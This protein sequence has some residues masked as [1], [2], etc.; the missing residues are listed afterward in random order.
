MKHQFAALAGFLS[1]LSFALAESAPVVYRASFE[2]AAHHEAR[3]TA[4]FR[5]LVEGPFVFRMSRS[6]PGRYAL[7]EFAKNVYDVSAVDG[8]GRALEVEQ[9]D[10]YS[11]RVEGHDGAVTVSYTLYADRADGTYS[12]I[13]RTHAHLNMPATFIWAEG[14][15]DRTIEISFS[16]P[17]RRWKAATQ[18][19]PS[20]GRLTFTAPD[21]QYFMDSPTELSAYDLRSWKLPDGQTVRLA[22]H[23]DGN[24]EDMDRYAD[25][26]KKIVAEQIEIFGAAP[27]FDHGVY[28]FIA[29]YLPHV[30]GDGME[31]RNSTILSSTKGL[32]EADFAQIGTLSHEFFH[33]WNVE[34]MRPAELEPF[35]FARTNPTPSLWFAEGFTNYY[36]DLA[37]V[38]SGVT[39]LDDYL[40]D[41]AGTLRFIINAP[42]RKVG[43][44]Q[45]MSLEAAFVDAARAIDPDNRPNM[46][47]SYYPYGEVIA[48]ALDLTLRT[49]FDGVT[50][51]DYMRHLWKTH[52]VTE[53]PYTHEDLREGLA[54]VTGDTDFADSFFASYIEDGE[55]PDFEPLLAAAGLKLARENPG[56]ASLGRVSFEEH[57]DAVLI[58]SNTLAGSPLYE[59]GLDRGD[60]ILRIGRFNIDSKTDYENALERH[61]PGDDVAIKFSSRGREI[62]ATTT[63]VAD[64]ALKITPYEEMETDLTNHQKA[65]RMNWLN[66]EAG[67]E[68]AD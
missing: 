36:G 16:A 35:D 32:Y 52:G 15:E 33:A 41:L 51:D 4:S 55:L 30:S 20:R 25:M 67:A 26:A 50:L 53:T 63:F 29:D 68:V 12:Q 58:A 43:S 34:R 31:H 56:K 45:S 66:A 6:S 44:P 60:D 57:G 46:F 10:P 64:D 23:H 28:T 11:W 38:R 48:L 2:N 3:I 62:E 8:A 49:Q 21:L 7:H 13:D 22:V 9:R 54:E 39:P 47:V 18:L 40:E 37:R 42:G 24:A 1:A 19:P 14:L 27:E 59:A 17:D 61:K 65:F 5:D